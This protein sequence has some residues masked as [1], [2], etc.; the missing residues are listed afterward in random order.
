[1]LNHW[2]QNRGIVYLVVLIIAVSIRQT[3]ILVFLSHEKVDYVY[4]VFT[5]FDPIFTLIGPCLYYYFR[6]IIKGKIDY[7]LGA[8]I[9][10]IPFT[11][12]LVNTIPYYFTPMEIKMELIN[13]LRFG[14]KSKLT[15]VPYLVFDS[16]VQ[17]IFISVT[18]FC[19]VIFSIYYVLQQ[20]R[21]GGSYMK[22]KVSILLNKLILVS[23]ICY[24]GFGI[25]GTYVYLNYF[26]DPSKSPNQSHFLLLLILPL[27]FFL[28]PSWLYGDHEKK[29]L[30]DRLSQAFKMTF[31]D[32]EISETPDF[33]KQ[34]DLD[35]IIAYISDSKPYLNDNF[36]L[37]DIS[38]A[39][40]IP[41]VRVTN[42]FNKQLK[43]SFPVYRNKLRVD[44]ATTLLAAGVYLN[45]SI[46][47]IAAKSGFK[48]KS[49]FY[50][51]FKAE[52]GLTPVDWIKENL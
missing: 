43:V 10:L 1:M 13:F 22:K 17:K 5:H 47:G 14:Q 27:A 30:F 34:E 20:K 46:E 36:S 35:R 38:R 28:F 9:H 11:L 21:M 41:H 29:S 33:G 37:H 52:Y 6:S 2:N 15:A 4:Y 8:L 19:Y 16:S 48:S 32:G 25:I 26:G 49:A 7:S 23:V 24:F 45:T 18:N 44:Y 12:V 3:T 50:L 42:C 51:A 31:S 39:L 40:N